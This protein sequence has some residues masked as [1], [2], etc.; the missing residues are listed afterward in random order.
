M[1]RSYLRN[2]GSNKTLYIFIWVIN[3]PELKSNFFTPHLPL[4][5]TL[6]ILD[7]AR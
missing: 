7:G 4:N 6:T 5:C 2:N 1:F 3:A